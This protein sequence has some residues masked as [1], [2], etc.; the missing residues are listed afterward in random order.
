MQIDAVVTALRNAKFELVED[1][2]LSL[3][4]I[5]ERAK[6][7][8]SKWAAHMAAL[9]TVV[10][11]PFMY[12]EEEM[13]A[14]EGSNFGRLAERVRAQAATDYTA[15]A[16]V[17]A[18]AGARAGF[19]PALFTPEAYRWGL[20]LVWSRF[21]SLRVKRQSVKYMVPYF[22]MFNH[23]PTAAVHHAY[24]AKTD[25]VVLTSEQ[26]W[27]AGS[28]VCINYG[29]LSNISLLKL[30]GFVQQQEANLEHFRTEISI[31]A[32][33]AGLEARMRMIEKHAGFA[34]MPGAVML[35]KV[36][37]LAFGEGDDEPA[38]MRETARKYW[39]TWRAFVG[40]S[41]AVPVRGGSVMQITAELFKDVPHT[42]LLRT[43]RI[44]HC[45]AAQLPELDA[46]MRRKPDEGTD[47]ETEVAVLQQLSRALIEQTKGLGDKRP[48]DATR[49]AELA[50]VTAA[51]EAAMAAAT[52]AIQA[53]LTAA[54]CAVAAPEVAPVEHGA[55]GDDDEDGGEEVPSIVAGGGGGGGGGK[56]KGGKGGKGGKGKGDKK[57]GG[58]GKATAEA[59]GG[60]AATA[61]STV[62]VT[63]PIAAA[64]LAAGFA[65]L[66]PAPATSPA[67]ASHAYRLQCAAYVRANDKA[68]LESQIRW[69]LTDIQELRGIAEAH[70]AANAEAAG[71]EEGGAAAAASGGGGGSSGSEGAAAGGAG[72]A[73]A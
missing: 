32:T 61:A 64:A 22:D 50:A 39:T 67:D 66:P 62:P 9:P 51:G 13:K 18:S 47:I 3:M 70:N 37:A 72:G 30:H 5:H 34:P 26:P 44:L 35:G 71:G 11:S 6:G 49:V 23:A 45:D 59:A 54:G 29:E 41:G 52:A 60:A 56:R 43:L 65:A 33:L 31:P 38:E 4:L 69:M 55:V 63:P 42:A 7:A 14:F 15:I 8:G 1:D 20:A 57:K 17:L 28:Q 25:A 19:P 10:D 16:A 48:E 27:D 68:I 2:V 58:A 21:V 46:A 24:D 36:A 53:S 12:T 73:S 40:S